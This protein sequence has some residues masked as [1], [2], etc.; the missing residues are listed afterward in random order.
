[1]FMRAPC[2]HCELS[3]RYWDLTD[4]C[5]MDSTDDRSKFICPSFDFSPGSKFAVSVLS[6]GSV[7]S[8]GDIVL[9][10]SVYC[11][12]NDINM[13][14]AADIG[15]GKHER[16]HAFMA[17]PNGPAA[18]AGLDAEYPLVGASVERVAMRKRAIAKGWADSWEDANARMRRARA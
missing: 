14:P 5:R 4:F 6:N 16:S 1:M 10:P 11:D 13:E 17:T 8:K 15:Q 9:G 12:T 18:I 3:V 7:I 2:S